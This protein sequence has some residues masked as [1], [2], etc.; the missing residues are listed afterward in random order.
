MANFK[1]IMAMCLDGVS[2]S[3]IASALGCSRRDIAKTKAVIASQSVTKESFPQLA[4]EFFKHHFGDNRTVRKKQYHQPDFPALAKRLAANKHLTRHKL[5]M[6]YLATDAGPDE[7]KYQYS[8]FCVHLR[9]YVLATGLDSVIEHEPG[10]ELYV[11]WAG[12][13]IA[14]IDQA[15]GLVGMKASLFVA[16]CPY[17]G[18]LFALAAAN[19]KMPAWI[20]CHV[21][22]LNYLG[23]VPGIIVPDNASTATYRPVKAQPSRR[24]HARYAD[25]ATYYDLLIVPARPGKPKDKAAVERAVQTAYSRILGYFDGHIFY[26][27]DELN[28]AII[29]RVDD[30]N[31]NLV[32]TDGMTRRELFDADE[33]P[34]MRDLPAVA[35]TEVS[36]RDVKVDRNWHIT[37]D[38]QYYSVPF[39]LIGKTLRARLTNDLV[40]IF[41]GDRLVAEHSRLHGFRY[42]Y[43]TDP[44]HNPDG[45][46]HGVEV[47]T[48]DELLKRASSFGPATIKVITQILK[49][50]EKAVPRGLHTARNVLVKLGNKHNKTSL[51]PACQQILEHNLAPNMQVIARIQT[52]IARNHQQQPAPSTAV[53]G[54]RAR[55]P[56][57][58]DKVAGAVFIRPASHYD[59]VKEI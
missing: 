32:R 26:S 24:I 25:F 47:L 45:D 28:E 22:A 53:L 1:E 54:D 57:D 35:F 11:D 29:I 52:D 31:D 21:Q 10:Q 19:E 27:L 49:R 4:P 9:D 3:A 44:A 42:R 46:T 34:L 15:T 2:Y 48:R 58:I 12:D 18:L 39:R 33:A 51:E 38:Y 59:Q 17:S 40:S 5:W 13:K 8:Q 7:A 37:C 16:V 23:K 20:D 41:D 30:I 6:D 56:V 36:W 55:K 43:S 14:I 50:N